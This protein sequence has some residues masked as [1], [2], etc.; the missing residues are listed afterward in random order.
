[1][2]SIPNLILKPVIA[3]PE[4]LQGYGWLIGEPHGP[5]REKINLYGKE[6]RVLQPAAFHGNNDLCLNLVTFT[7]RALQVRWME[8]HNKHTQTFI[9]LKGHPFYMI[10]G[11]PTRMRPD[12]SINSAIVDLPDPDNVTAFYFDGSGGLVMDVGGWHEVPFPTEAQ[13]NFVC[14]C[15]NETNANLEDQGADGECVGGD[16]KKKNIVKNFGY[17][18]EI[19]V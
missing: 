17:T 7:Q 10:L 3:T 2:T 19:Q 11:K 1:M 14:I 6:V 15:T 16:L 4:S 12:G 9:P 13:T 8:Y 18:F 5:E